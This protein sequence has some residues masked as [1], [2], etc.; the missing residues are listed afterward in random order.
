MAHATVVIP[1]RDRSALLRDTL[2]RVREAVPATVPVLVVDSASEDD[3]SAVAREAGVEVIRCELPGASVARNAGWRHARTPVVAFLDDDCLPEPGWV[4]ALA[5]PF[6]DPTVGVVFG[7]VGL[8]EEGTAALAILER[9]E[10]HG[11]DVGSPLADYGYTA[12][13]AFRRDAL[14]TLGGF[15]EVLGAGS[16]LHASEDKDL[17]WRLLRAGWAG[18]YDPAARVVHRQWRSRS[19]ALRTYFHYGIGEAA[20]VA[21][22]RRID[23]TAGA[24]LGHQAGLRRQVTVVTDALRDRYEYGALT[25]VVGA[26]GAV[27]GRVLARRYRI[28]DG[29]FVP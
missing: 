28:V 26:A 5:A 12:N 13:V 1:T 10:A 4:Q 23:P 21:K 3:T 20:F 7:R 22:A 2:A 8:E 6:D 15:D 29:R 17:T 19:T 18:R 24:T 11:L 25:G 14:A 16:P 9:D 27:V